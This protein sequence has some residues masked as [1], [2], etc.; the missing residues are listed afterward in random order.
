MAKSKTNSKS[1]K[2]KNLN[3]V[4]RNLLLYGCLLLVAAV[5]A[6]GLYILAGRSKAAVGDTYSS[7]VYVDIPGNNINQCRGSSCFKPEVTQVSFYIV[8]QSCATVSGQQA[9]D[10]CS[11]ITSAT[12]ASCQA[13]IPVTPGDQRLAFG[14]MSFSA[15][16]PNARQ[17]AGQMYYDVYVAPGSTCGSTARL[18]VGGTP[19]PTVYV[20]LFPPC[21]STMTQNCPVTEGPPTTPTSPTN[22]LTPGDKTGPT[23]TGPTGAGPSGSGPSGGSRNGSTA[24]S[25]SD[26]PNSIPSSSSQGDQKQSTIVPTPFFDGKQYNPGSSAMVSW[27]KDRGVVSNLAANWPLVGGSIAFGVVAMSAAYWYWRKRV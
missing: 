25:Q 5:T 10:Y 18:G 14:T 6:T 12:I 3:L 9:Q 17:G 7:S 2:P 23:G 27:S 19:N 8:A 16:G 11:D 21:G 1:R 24:T 13:G 15:Y 4:K 22:P 20:G 26:S